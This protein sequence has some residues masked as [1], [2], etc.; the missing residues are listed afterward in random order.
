[1]D[2]PTLVNIC[3]KVGPRSSH[4]LGRNRFRSLSWRIYDFFFPFDEQIGKTG[5]Q[6]LIRWSLQHGYIPLPKSDKAERIK[7]NFDVFSFELD[8]ESMAQLDSLDQGDAGA[9][10]WN[11]TLVP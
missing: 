5:A 10:S 7:E 9:I 2:H 11:P 4:L 3:N 8:G 1:M 6:V